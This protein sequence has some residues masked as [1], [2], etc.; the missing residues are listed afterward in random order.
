MSATRASR[1]SARVARQ[2]SP[3][4]SPGSP[5]AP[6]EVIIVSDSDEEPDFNQSLR[7]PTPPSRRRPPP[8]RAPTPVPTAVLNSRNILPQPRD[9]SQDHPQYFSRQ[10]LVRMPPAHELWV[11][12]MLDNHTATR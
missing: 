6:R 7:I 11:K 2:A 5:E 4:V 3:E 8:Q 10:E 12:Q 1:R 9:F